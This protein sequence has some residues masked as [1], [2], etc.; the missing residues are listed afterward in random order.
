MYAVKYICVFGGYTD[1]GDGSE[2]GSTEGEALA[3]SKRSVAQPGIAFRHE[4]VS[5]YCG[6]NLR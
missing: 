4:F 3:A 1:P 5:A 2:G 6:K